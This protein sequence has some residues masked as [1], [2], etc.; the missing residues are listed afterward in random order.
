MILCDDLWC[1]ESL[2]QNDVWGQIGR[3]LIPESMST[4]HLVTRYEA[5]LCLSDSSQQNGERNN[6]F[7]QTIEFL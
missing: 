5:G 1:R 4:A 6:L 3:M 2:Q 7:C